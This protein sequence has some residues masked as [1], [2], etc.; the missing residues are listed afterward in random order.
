MT[1]APST[2]YLAA[3]ALA[4]PDKVALLEHRPG[5][6]ETRWTYAELNRRVNRLANALRARGIGP[7]STI[8]WC[9]MNSPDVVTL[10]QAGRKLGAT[11]VPLNYRLSPEEAAYVTDNSDAT[12]AWI[13]AEQVELFEQIREHTPKLTDVFVFGGEPGAG[14]TAAEELVAGASEEEPPPIEV[15]SRTMIYTSGTTG[16]PKGAVRTGQGNPD[17]LGGMVAKLGYQPDEIYMTT[18]PLYHSGP[19]GFMGIAYLMGHTVVLQRKFDPEDWLRLVDQYKVT[20]TFAAPTPIRRICSLPDEVKDRY[21]KTSLR[22]MVANAAP[23]PFPLKQAYVADFPEE[24]LFEVYGSTELGVNMI[25]EPADQMRKPGSCGK[26]APFVEVKLLDDDGN[27]VTEPNAPG[28]VFVRSPSVFTTYHK[29]QDKYEEDTRG[30]FHTVGDVA[31]RDEEGFY[32]ICDRK[33]DMIIS[34]GMNIYPAEIESALE[35]HDKIFEAAVFGIPSEEWGE[36]V[37]ATVVPIPGESL[38]VDEVAAFAREHLASYKVPR[39]IEFIDELPKTGSGK[40]LK[41][42]LREPYWKD[43]QTNV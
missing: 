42:E 17:Q 38:T 8:L 6:E 5:D 25:L 19:G 43:Q 27:E 29:A 2:D 35:H 20:S 1:E 37:H 7:E 31:Y 36:S 22:V 14:M 41:R 28:E 16:N 24:S 10:G 32:F 9:G 23:W 13:D 11:T 21:D 30:D 18:G 4:N 33:K 15:E 3:H 39:S 40:I 26:P 12:F 34:G